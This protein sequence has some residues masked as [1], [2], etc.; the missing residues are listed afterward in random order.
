[1]PTKLKKIDP[2]GKYCNYPGVDFIAP[3]LDEDADFWRAIH[4]CIAGSE[5][6]RAYFSPLPPSSYHMTANNLY[7]EHNTRSEHWQAF[8][9]SKLEFFR[10]LQGAFDDRKFTPTLTVTTVY[11]AGS[12]RLHV[13]LPK[14]QIETIFSIS[15]RFGIRALVPDTFHITL[16][17]HYRKLIPG[18]GETDRVVE[19]LTRDISA[20]CGTRG[21]RIRLQP[22]QLCHFND[23]TAFKPWTAET[24]PF[25]VKASALGLF[26]VSA[27]PHV[28]VPNATA[29]P[30]RTPSIVDPYSAHD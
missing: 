15:E 20:L 11:V 18:A 29:E 10:L 27:S 8:I 28:A 6:A 5:L 14:E 19:Q 23:M 3:V 7:T 9:D 22:L 21:H 26:A 17:Y 24:N 12:V 4:D 25:K 2:T 1:M 30:V 13:D 16:A